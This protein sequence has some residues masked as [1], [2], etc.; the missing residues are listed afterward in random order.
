MNGGIKLGE[1]HVSFKMFSSYFHH[2]WGM[3]IYVRE[4]ENKTHIKERDFHGATTHFLCF[5]CLVSLFIIYSPRLRRGRRQF[6][7]PLHTEETSSVIS[8]LLLP[9][10]RQGVSRIKGIFKHK[11][12]LKNGRDILKTM[13]D[14]TGLHILL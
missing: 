3:C 6:K 12:H 10:S 7:T 14:K 8:A 4:I 5:I 2:L 1:E 9:F 11:S 13:F